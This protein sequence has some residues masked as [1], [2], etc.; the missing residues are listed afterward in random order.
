MSV[1]KYIKIILIVVLYE[2]EMWLVSLNE[3]CVSM[4][5]V[6]AQGDPCTATSLWSVVRSHILLYSAS[7]SVP[8]TKY[9]ILHSRISSH[10]LGSVFT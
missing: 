4:R 2:C 8:L 7:S 10:S 1:F 6:G 3:Q 9:S 5:R